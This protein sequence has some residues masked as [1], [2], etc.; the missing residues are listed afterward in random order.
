MSRGR[1]GLGFAWDHVVGDFTGGNYYLLGVG[2]LERGF[3]GYWQL[4]FENCSHL[5][6]VSLT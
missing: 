1:G 4:D 3:I 5:M 6:T 2:I